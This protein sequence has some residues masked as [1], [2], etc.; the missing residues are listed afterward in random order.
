MMDRYNVSDYGEMVA[1]P[2]RMAA[3]ARAIEQRVK[4]GGVVVDLG[5]GVGLFALLA[6]QAGARLV[7]A[8]EPNEAIVLLEAA[9]AERGDRDAVR[10]IQK[11]SQAVS[12]PERA[13]LIVSDLRGTLPLHADHI[14]TI[15]DAR[16][17]FLAPGGTLIPQAD[18]LWSAVVE[19]EALYKK[20]VGP[21][22]SLPGGFRME[23][24]HRMACNNWVRVER[25][26][27]V[28]KDQLLTPA[29]PW[30]DLDYMTIKSP[31]A[32]GETMSTV[33]RS[34]LAHGLVVGFD[35]TLAEGI[36][37]SNLP[38]VA[39][40][41]SVYGCGFFPWPEPVALVDG[42]RVSVRI[43]A[44]F[45]GGD[46]IWRWDSTVETANGTRKAAFQQSTFAGIPRSKGRLLK[47]EAG[48]VPRLDTE[49]QIDR[50][51]LNGMDQKATVS[52]IA[53]SLQR[54][55]P[56]EFNTPGSALARVGQLSRRY[57]L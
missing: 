26:E 21:W 55:F 1:D 15:I 34:G 22:R 30:A 19:S 29:T 50:L 17:R 13:D 41:P 46:Y 4:A 25:S 44:R 48:Y 9:L 43:D 3:Y 12:L 20:S 28:R 7:F 23:A 39:E 33:D 38:G 10:C 11:V 51:V 16:E 32:G 24:A 31:N 8:I 49:G 2:V 42:D 57:S 14:E 45:S 54:A 52:A 53:A 56:S 27:R 5:A 40:Q 47:G 18:R 6:R 36:G 37:F 35:A